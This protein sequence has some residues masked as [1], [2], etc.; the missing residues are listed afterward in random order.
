MLFCNLV[1]IVLMLLKVYI[2]RPLLRTTVNISFGVYTAK[3]QW[4]DM[5][6]QKVIEQLGYS[7]KQA[8][9]YLA[10]LSLGEAH[11]SDIASKVK[12]P[13]STV[14]VIV[15]ELHKGGLMNFYVMRRY[16]YWV[17]E[18]PETLL[19]NFQKREKMMKDALP[20]LT[21][22]RFEA[23]KGNKYDKN[24]KK[25]I[26]TFRTIADASLQAV[27]ITNSDAEIEYANTV[28]LKQFGYSLNEVRGENPRLFKSGKTP[29]SVYKKMWSALS[30]GTMFQSDEI[31]DKRKDGTHF[32]LLTTIFPVQHGNRTFYIQILDD[33]TEKK[34]V[35]KLSHSFMQMNETISR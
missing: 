3:K 33:I 17:A 8:K 27:L 10:S 34:R 9:V 29:Q 1:G 25:S 7:P 24:Y 11:I 13:R 6:N 28:W 22:L 30:R 2:L 15:D 18:K 16:K 19:E 32:N 21:A 12:M 20:K 5:Q 35:E 23:R 26:D 14:Q 4:C 31:V